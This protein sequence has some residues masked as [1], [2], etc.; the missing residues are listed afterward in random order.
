LRDRLVDDSW[1]KFL[2]PWP[3]S[4][5]YFLVSAKLSPDAA[6]GIYLVDVFDNMTLIKELDGYALLEPVPLAARPTPPV[7]PSQVAPH[8]KSAS[9]YIADVYAGPG[10]EGV[11][12][13]TV[14]KLRLFTYHFAYHGMGGQIDRVGFD[15]PWDVKRVLGTVPV[16]PDG[17]AH[18]KVPANTP[19]SIQ[20]LDGEGKSLQ[21]M[22]SW[23]VGMPGEAV[24]C[25]GCHDRQHSAAYNGATLALA[26]P[27]SEITQWYG[28][29]RGF[30][31]NREVQPV[32]D[33]HCT[34]C[35]DGRHGPDGAP[36]A[37]LRKQ[38][39][40][41]P[42]SSEAIY[43]DNASFPPAYLE[44]RRFV[45]SPTIESDMHLLTPCDFH[46]DTSRLVQMLQ[47]GHHGVR[48]DSE[49]WDRLITWIDLHAPCHGTW[50]EIA[51]QER[52]LHQRDQRRAMLS[53][54]AGIEED[55][56]S[57]HET[58]Y[59]AQT[60][61]HA[62][63]VRQRDEMIELAGWPFDEGEARRRQE[64]GGPIRQ[65]VPLGKG[66]ELSLVRVPA[67]TFVMGDLAGHQDEPLRSVSID[68]GFWLGQF[69]LTNEQ[70]R[71]FDTAHDSRLEHGDFLQFSEEER[72][73]SLDQPRQ[74]VVR[75]SF[76]EA[77]AFC[78]WL[79]E[80]SGKRFRLPTEEEWE[81]ACRAGTQ[82]PLNYGGVDDDFSAHANL[83][84]A[85][86]QRI[87]T[88]EPWKL[89]SGAISPWRPADVRFDDLARASAPVGSYRANAWGLHDM[90]G[91]AA[92]WTCSTDRSD[93]AGD[94]MVVR[95][96]S[97]NDRPRDSRCAFRLSYHAW[98]R[99]YDVGFRV[100]CE[101]D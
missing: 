21:L 20:P 87:D 50:H 16:M 69:E 2:H 96:G 9:V 46:A 28:P 8:E 68:N 41:R 44:L 26:K 52:V 80:K 38:A 55:P 99:V 61:T 73:Y 36:L 23:F 92:E 89:P 82:A 77:R 95:G 78:R 14:K 24:S 33:A 81:Y 60:S 84:D 70:Y 53:R 65:T 32:L 6:W 64:A 49:A 97:W 93:S 27:P 39:P 54:Y 88:Y 90:H 85:A 3:L 83:A 59:V 7:I 100:V 62:P 29:T 101:A 15:G 42:G 98:Q 34:G 18:F 1:P 17:S 72:G 19:I 13:E 74:P 40:V 43:N 48:L 76:A 25:G 57:I 31:F 11:P 30:S 71:V 67:G 63:Q 37:D 47:K 66:I 79:S 35:H 91:N 51:G 12:R 4:D 86:L 58:T 22:R 94:R 5:K 75:V 45:R 56:E 10:L